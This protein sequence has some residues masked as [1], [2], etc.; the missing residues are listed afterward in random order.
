MIS[1]SGDTTA[2]FWQDLADQFEKLVK[3]EK[4]VNGPCLKAYT[5]VD[6]IVTR[7]V[8]NWRL[9]NCCGAE[10]EAQ[11]EVLGTKGGR[12]LGILPNPS[13]LPL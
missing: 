13:V 9:D 1:A 2:Q 5:I 3:D 11:F 10:I 12:E 8:A 4:R 7:V 6:S